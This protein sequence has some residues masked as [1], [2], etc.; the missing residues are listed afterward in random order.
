M[1]AGGIG[2]LA[3]SGLSQ[4]MAHVAPT[5]IKRKNYNVLFIAVDDLRPQLGCYGNKEIK[6]PN[7]DRLAK[8]CVVF[9][10]AYTQMATC[11]PSRA[12]LMSGYR[13]DTH[14]AY[15][16]RA[17]DA[18]LFRQNMPDAI[19]LAHHFKNNGYHTEGYGK[20]FHG[21][22]CDP[23]AWSVPYAFGGAGKLAD[24][25]DIQKYEG[26]IREEQ[27]ERYLGIARREKLLTEEDVTTYMNAENKE[28]LS[29]RL[30]K[31]FRRGPS[32]IMHDVPDICLS[33]ARLAQCGV[34]A[35]RKLAKQ[36]TKFFLA[37]G[38]RKPHLKFEAPKKYYDMYPP[39]SITLPK[40]MYYPKNSPEIARTSWGEMKSYLDIDRKWKSVP[41]YKALELRRGYYACVSYIDAQLGRLLDELERQKLTDNTIIILWGDHG[42]K[43]GEHN[44]WSKHTCWEID[45]NA[46]LMMGVPG[47]KHAG[48]KSKALVEF[49][50]IYS[51][52]SDACGLVIPKGLHGV[53]FMPVLED[54]ARKW[55]KAALSQFHRKDPK[56]KKSCMGYTIT[57]GRYRYTEWQ[58]QGTKKLLYKELYDHKNDPDENVSVHDEK[59]YQAV[60][61]NLSKLLNG[62]WQACLPDGVRPL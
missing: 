14:K 55:K 17:P 16:S 40:N 58:E 31:L 32:W 13:P 7:F 60:I 42:W 36:K 51:T 56:T 35:L 48:K 24:I 59:Q 29:K 43:L 57:D 18:E 10:H 6:T 52:L 12:T 45:T 47:M 53:S 41:K 28:K 62:G 11:N 8:K 3:G 37:V 27:K 22:F 30:K 19:T 34:R 2:M 38:F 26:K 44:M 46:P 33:D 4:H 23:P 20:I 39:S 21:R 54:P 5:R 1:T 61:R 25:E 50:D 49:A 9:E 15:F